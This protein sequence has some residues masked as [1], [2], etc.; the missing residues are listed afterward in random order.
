[1]SNIP[2]VTDLYDLEHTIAKE[3]LEKVEEEE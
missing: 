2:T 1:M 3:L